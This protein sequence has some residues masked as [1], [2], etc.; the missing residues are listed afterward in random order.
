MVINNLEEKDYHRRVRCVASNRL[1]L[2]QTFITIGSPSPPD[3]PLDLELMNVT[4][5]TATISWQPGF[6]GGSEQIFEIRF[7]ET[8]QHDH[9]TVNTSHSVC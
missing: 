6:G 7:Q 5:Q 2:G 1:G 9:K 8:G 3:I 4:D